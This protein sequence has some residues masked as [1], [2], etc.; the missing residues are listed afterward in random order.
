MPLIEQRIQFLREIPSFKSLTDEQFEKL[1]GFCE[2]KTFAAGTP[3]FRQGDMGESLFIVVD[4][5]VGIEREVTNEND[6][7]ALAIVESREYFGLFSLF[8]QAQRTATATAMKDSVVLQIK[9]EAFVTFALQNPE[10]LIELNH[11]LSLRLVEAYDKISE[12]TR[13]RSKPRE[14][15]K[16]YEKLDF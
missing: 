11:V 13:S 12:I 3:I 8:S 7:V 5:R 6:T 16:L 14:L 4:G 2:T 15:R 1:A 9:R 10:L